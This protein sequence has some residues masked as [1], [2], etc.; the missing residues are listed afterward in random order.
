[1]TFPQLGGMAN[2]DDTAL[3]DLGQSLGGVKSLKLGGQIEAYVDFK[4]PLDGGNLGDVDI[5]F[6]DTTANP[7]PA[8]STRSPS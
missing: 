1:M 6:K 8:R 5:V 3:L 4:S 2:S 7:T